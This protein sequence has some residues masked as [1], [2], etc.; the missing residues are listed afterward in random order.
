MPE[1]IHY[2]TRLSRELLNGHADRDKKESEEQD[3]KSNTVY[4]QRLRREQSLN[5]VKSGVFQTPVKDN[6]LAATPL[7]MCV[8]D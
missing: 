8:C 7:G 5:A 1:L 3:S 6:S 2:V 4:V